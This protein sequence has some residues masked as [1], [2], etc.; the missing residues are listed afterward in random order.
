MAKHQDTP[1]LD[2]LGGDDDEDSDDGLDFDPVKMRLR[3]PKS[4]YARSVKKS[5]CVG[6]GFVI[7]VIVLVTLV[8]AVG[9]LISSRSPNFAITGQVYQSPFD[10]REYTAIQLN[11][12]LRV[13]LISD[14]TTDLSAA[15]M[16]VSVGSFSDTV[17]GLAHFCEHMLFYGSKKYPKEDEYSEFL[18]QHGGYDNAYTSTEN[19]NYFFRVNSDSLH[20]ALDRFAQFFIAP[21][22]AQDGVNREMNAINAEHLKNLQ[23]DNWRQWQLLKSVSNPDHP[24]HNFNTGDLQTLNR[25]DILSKLKAFYSTHYSANQVTSFSYTCVDVQL[26]VCISPNGI[27]F[28]C[29]LSSCVERGGNCI[30][31]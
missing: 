2:Q 28:L 11:N 9:L 16:D 15:A 29:P 10:T 12:N 4:L 5:V 13:L 26:Y 30:N 8:V 20:E 18:T 19:T 14:P 24:F 3:I 21:I 27:S 23:S 22:L 17:P 6:L 31:A 25:S 1:L 7:V